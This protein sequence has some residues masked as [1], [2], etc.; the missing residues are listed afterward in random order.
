M[1]GIILRN[2]GVDG[3]VVD[4][5]I[6]GATV[7]SVG[8]NLDREPGG[9][10]LEIEG[11]QGAL[12]P[13]LHDHHLHL[14]AAAAADSSIHLGPP[15][16]RDRDQFVRALQQAAR[17]R[18]A[19]AWV[20]GVGYHHSVAGDLDRWSL[21]AV[22]ADRPVRVQHATG[23]EWILNSAALRSI[24]AASADGRFYGQD[25]WLRTRREPSHPPDLAP[26][27]ERLARFGVTGVTD[28]TPSDHLS[29]VELLGRAVVDGALPQ[30]VM[31]TGSP[32][33]A[34]APRV[35]GVRWGPVKVV[36]AD[37]DLPALD[38][39]GHAFRVAHEAARPVAVHCVTPVALALALAAWGEAGVRR[40]D[41]IE[42]GSVITPEAAARV[43][44]LGLVVV[45]QPGFVASRGDLYLEEVEAAL[46]PHLYPCA[47]LLAR[48][49][50]VGGSTDA[51]YGRL[52]PWEAMAAAA[53]RRT[54]S[55][56]LLNGDERV[57]AQ[58]ALELFLTRPDDPGGRRRV[59]RPGEAAN[60][61]LLDA[62]L[63]VALAQP[64][65]DHVAATVIGGRVVYRR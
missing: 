59:V 54:G 36:I 53:E 45:T 5:G 32:L 34:G 2:V 61:C 57:P 64:A 21:D 43:A 40:G 39:L 42:H 35:D 6:R 58:R 56:A 18:P 25:Q 52:D 20:R 49:I 9:E 23:A 38:D 31:V 65:S 19:E 4:V 16:V 26:L 46:L 15:D 30:E 62:P 51:P 22:V 17:G 55:G 13:G 50:A 47:S 63:D 8:P 12:I 24:G 11:R 7:A 14:L 60:L 29:S 27:G 3:A 28:A 44:E 41:R 1:T 37:H 48:G 33:L 10:E